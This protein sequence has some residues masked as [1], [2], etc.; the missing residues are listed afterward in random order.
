MS[1]SVFA[2]AALA[3]HF[4]SPLVKIRPGTPPPPE[5]AGELSLAR[6]ECEGLQLYLH[7]EGRDTRTQL[8]IP[9]LR[10]EG[11][12]DGR[13]LQ[14]S[15]YEVHWVPVKIPSNS[16]GATGLWPD[17]LVPLKTGDAV[18]SDA[19]TPAVAYLEVCAPGDLPPG[20][21]RG[22][23]TLTRGKQ[24]RTLTLAVTV[25]PFTLPATSS[26]PNTFGI[27]RYSIAKGHGL[28]PE[29][30]EAHTLL[31]DYV[32]ELLRHRVSAHGMGMTPPTVRFEGSEP[33][34]DFTAWDREFEP[35][36]LGKALDSGAR[37]T[38]LQ[39][40]DDLRLT[41]AQRSAYLT[42]FR[43]HVKAK[44]FKGE[45]FFY[46]KD[47]PRP[48]DHPLVRAQSRAVRGSEGVRLLLTSPFDPKIAGTADILAPPLNCFFPRSGPDTCPH[49]FT[50]AQLRKKLQGRAKLFWYQ[51]CLV[52]GCNGG[53]L[54][55]PVLERAFSGWA[56]YML[57]HPA[58]SN[59]AMG[60]LGFLSGVDG[61]LY[62]D[63]V[64]A[65]GGDPWKDTFAFGGNG[66]GTFFYPG[67]PARLGGKRHTPVSSLR[68]KHVRDGLEDYEYLRL[69]TERGQGR[70]AQRLVK[71]LT[72]NGYTITA[73]PAAWEKTREAMIRALRT[74]K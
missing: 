71:Q 67:T 43:E 65:Y 58:T 6:N 62:F 33:R 41:E 13:A 23:I 37:F 10:P 19:R 56:S 35:F 59:R 57:D 25:E 20:T 72:R 69:L 46:A 1:L 34:I 3:A 9:P 42:A 52:H 70:L 51:S 21:Y 27:S 40:I 47:E 64:A 8:A 30:P 4:V 14:I 48:E 16:Q 55:D 73:D 26:L 63:T 28:D 15:A 22:P 38:T 74:G 45:V 11:K 18:R 68:L 24:T 5:R 32:R 17:P 50:A 2:A 61:E 36:L 7:P 53:P 39:L 29:S 31:A 12:R 60:P 44:G 66:D 49:I 54:E